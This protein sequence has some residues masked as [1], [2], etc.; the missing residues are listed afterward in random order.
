VTARQHHGSTAQQLDALDRLG[1][2]NAADVA[3]L[4][5]DLRDLTDHVR[6]LSGVLVVNGIM[7]RPYN[8]REARAEVDALLAKHKHTPAEPPRAVLRL[9]K[10]G[11]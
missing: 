5:A 10:N 11:H 7:P 8:P 3:A 9:V 1:R 4:R 2:Q 6:V